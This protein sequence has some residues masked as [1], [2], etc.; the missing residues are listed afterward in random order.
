MQ[1]F[2]TQAEKELN[3]KFQKPRAY[4][5]WVFFPA[6]LERNHFFFFKL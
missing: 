6:L 3:V 4:S 1:L 5:A 2:G